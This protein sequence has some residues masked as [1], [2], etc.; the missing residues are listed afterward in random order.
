MEQTAQA[1]QTFFLAGTSSRS[2]RQSG[3]QSG[4]LRDVLII[5]DSSGSIGQA[6]FDDSKAQLAKLIGFLCPLPDPFKGYQ[7]AA[8][9]EYSNN[10]DEL[11]DF[12]ANQDTAGV[13]AGINRMQ[14]VGGSTC[15]ATAFNYAKNT[16]F[17]PGRGIIS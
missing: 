8:L 3:A 7:R 11:F 9:I 17:T 4:Q 13:Q 6:F 16:M 5:F 2:K 1:V 10:V 12:D 14:Y 15:T